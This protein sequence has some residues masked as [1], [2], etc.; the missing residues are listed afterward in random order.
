MVVL[1]VDIGTS[2]IFDKDTPLVVIAAVLAL[3]VGAWSSRGG[4]RFGL[5]SEQVTFTII[6][7]PV[8]IFFSHVLFETMEIE[9]DV[10]VVVA[11]SRE[12][13]A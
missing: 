6:V 12:R 8:I 7:L 13:A 3:V 9:F 1:I 4:G 10:F 5:N 11:G 2:K